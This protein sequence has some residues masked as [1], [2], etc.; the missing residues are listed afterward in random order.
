MSVNLDGMNAGA[1]TC[2]A[3]SNFSDI[4]EEVGAQGDA[5]KQNRTSKKQNGTWRT[6]TVHDELGC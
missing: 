6:V 5:D 1:L 4:F 3:S 2:V